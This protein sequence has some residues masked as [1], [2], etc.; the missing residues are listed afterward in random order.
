MGLRNVTLTSIVT[1]AMGACVAKQIVMPADRHTYG[2]VWCFDC[3]NPGADKGLKELCEI[4]GKDE[5]HMMWD[6][7]GNRYVYVWSDCEVGKEPWRKF[8][9]N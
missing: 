9:A 6:T 3:C 1:L 4:A 7:D 8:E 5:D 2:W